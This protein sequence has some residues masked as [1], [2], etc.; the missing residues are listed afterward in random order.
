[1]EFVKNVEFKEIDLG[2][3]KV[4]VR[5]WKVKDRNKFK[6]IMRT[7]TNKNKLESSSTS[8]LTKDLIRALV[9]GCLEEPID[10]SPEELEYLFIKIREIS[11][12]DEFN[13]KYTCAE[14]KTK[15]DHTLKIEDTISFTFSEY[16]DITSDNIT[17]KMGKV[18]NSDFYNNKLYDEKYIDIFDIV[19]FCLHIHEFNSRKDF[20]LDSLIEEIAELDTNTLDNL[21]EQYDKIKF[22]I[23]REK[24]IKCQN[25]KCKKT[26]NF[27]FDEIPGFFPKTWT[28]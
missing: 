2:H 25:E 26:Y 8:S 22:S 19:D 9:V 13:L 15:N 14:C 5:K 16:V 6:E 4:K 18:L 10:L 28:I 12:S 3:K 23:V 20:T 27:V 21:L 11:I 1:M 17:V 24:E 7:V